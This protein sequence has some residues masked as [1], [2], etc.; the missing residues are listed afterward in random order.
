MEKESMNSFDEGA[1]NP[2]QVADRL[3]GTLEL[4]ADRGSLPLMEVARAEGLNKATAHRILRSLICMGYARQNEDGT[5][6]LTLKLASLAD[7]IV[8]REDLTA[9]I[10]P[11]LKQLMEE[12]GE[13]VHLVRR[14]G[15][16]AVYIDKVEAETGRVRMDSQIGGRIPLYCSGV[17]KA[18]CAE[19]KAAEVAEIWQESDIRRITPYTITDYEDF[20]YAL[21]EV[22]KKGYAL[23]NEENESGVR[24]IASSISVGRGGQ[25]AFSISAPVARMDNDRIRALAE[26]VIRTREAIRQDL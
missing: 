7:K 25:Y 24:C 23:D 6:G 2:I 12:T 14:E 3:F 26:S 21:E 9:V 4:L 8:G 15:T 1:K 17:G 20:L 13:T 18:I 11:Y 19:M 16:N 22:R 10:H 5:Y